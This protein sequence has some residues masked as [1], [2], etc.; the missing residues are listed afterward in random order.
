MS[1]SN[2]SDNDIVTGEDANDMAET[3]RARDD[4]R[5]TKRCNDVRNW[6]A[7]KV[8]N[9]TPQRI[10]DDIEKATV[11]NL[12]EVGA[13]MQK[14]GYAVLMDYTQA[15]DDPVGTLNPNTYNIFK[16]ENEPTHAQAVFHKTILPTSRQPPVMETI[17]EGV[18]INQGNNDFVP[19]KPSVPRPGTELRSIMKYGLAG[20]KAYQKQY[21]GQADDIIRGMFPA[22]GKRNKPNPAA[23][24]RNWVVEQNIVVGGVDHQHPHCDQG[25]AGSYQNDVI[26]PFVA[27]HGF[28]VNEFQMWILPQKLK[29]EYGFLYNFPQNAILFMRGDFIH[30]GACLQAA[31]GHIHFFPDPAAGWDDDNP[32]W[33]KGRFEAWI[34]DPPSYIT[35]DL[36]NTPFAFPTFSKRNQVGNQVITY[37]ASLTADLI[38]PI[39]RTKPLK[40]R[41]RQAKAGDSDADSASDDDA[42]LNADDQAEVEK[43]Q[44]LIRKLNQQKY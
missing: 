16:P 33:S 29:R 13:K 6:Q 10:H 44:A 40:K 20:Y 17:F 14:I 31:R 3:Q 32:Y 34:K 38:T 43:R 41:K 4:R 12:S 21:K 39:K 15:T 28:G 22:K 1:E 19:Q 8:R 36:R 11:R 30:A 7:G 26:F 24:P 25:K 37:P 23:E 27:V 2:V 5:S 42:D 18:M 9:C 35:Q